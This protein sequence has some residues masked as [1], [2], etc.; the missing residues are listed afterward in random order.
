MSEFDGYDPARVAN[1]LCVQ[2]RIAKLA[3]RRP[4]TLAVDYHEFALIPMLKPQTWVTVEELPTFDY[5]FRDSTGA[6]VFAIE[7][8]SQADLRKSVRGARDE[9]N[10][11][12]NQKHFKNQKREMLEAAA[13]Q[14]FVLLEGFAPQT[15]MFELNCE[16]HTLVRDRIGWLRTA[17]VL[18]TVLLLFRLALAFFEHG[19]P[20][21]EFVPQIEAAHE[22]FQG[23]ARKKPDVFLTFV[24]MLTQIPSVSPA[25]A[26][27]IAREFQT[28][29]ALSS[30][31]ATARIA[32]LTYES[33]KT[34]KPRRIG[35]ACAQI[36]ADTFSGIQNEPKPQKR[37]APVAQHASKRRCVE[38]FAIPD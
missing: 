11:A 18:D 13:D 4:F 2:D 20:A 36:V 24:R 1:I 38:E 15:R 5:I 37:K 14:K 32:D 17:D 3:Y 6:A 9:E 16:A 33:K 26:M 34:G 22:T 29:V 21:G 30:R 25:K 28:P 7:R 31:L 10:P 19:Q 23:G 35:P 27:S 12:K 8:K